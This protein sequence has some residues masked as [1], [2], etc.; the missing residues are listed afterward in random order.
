MAVV[1]IEKTR[2]D[3]VLLIKPPVFEDIRGCNVMLFDEREYAEALAAHGV[4]GLHFVKDDYSFS[5]QHVLRG[6]HGDNSTWKLIACQLGSFYLV[7]INN[8]PDHPQYRQWTAFTLSEHNRWQVLVPA[9]FVNGHLVMSET[10]IFYYKQSAYYNPGG[11][12]SLVWNDPELGIWW[13][14]QHPIVSQRDFFGRLVG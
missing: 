10:A 5:R 13:P 6:L 8:K 14:V 9:G 11:E 2:L 7:V 12:V 1:H 3:G 4:E